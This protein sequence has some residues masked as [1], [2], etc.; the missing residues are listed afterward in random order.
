[1]GD[2]ASGDR[3]GIATFQVEEAGAAICSDAGARR[4]NRL[5]WHLLPVP[6]LFLCESAIEKESSSLIGLIEVKREKRS[7]FGLVFGLG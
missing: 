7:G 1:M 3:R 4:C 2:V 6:D 5:G